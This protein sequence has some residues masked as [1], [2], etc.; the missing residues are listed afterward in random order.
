MVKMI[1]D[2]TP[3]H[4]PEQTD[5]GEEPNITAGLS[6]IIKKGR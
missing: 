1:A 6:K 3:K 4:S 2:I 5:P